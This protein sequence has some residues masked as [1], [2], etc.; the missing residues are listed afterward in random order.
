VTRT[1]LQREIV[2][3]G[4][5]NYQTTNHARFVQAKAREFAVSQ[6]Q[7]DHFRHS[8]KHPSMVG[9]GLRDVST[10]ALPIAPP[11]PERER[12][13][14]KRKKASAETA[15]TCDP[16]SGSKTKR[17]LEHSAGGLKNHRGAMGLELKAVEP[18]IK[19]MQNH[20]GARDTSS[21]LF[22]FFIFSTYFQGIILVSHH[23]RH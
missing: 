13:K 14:V 4:R 20:N 5:A 19:H 2:T 23:S 6:T 12:L 16:S 3:L 22:S 11:P 1:Q 9:C 10:P 17:K 21:N 8:K 15:D 7:L 18:L